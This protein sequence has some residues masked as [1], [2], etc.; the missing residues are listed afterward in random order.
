MIQMLEGFPDGVVAAVA[1]GRVTKRDYDE[2]LIPAV[3]AALGRRQ[4]LRCYYE[5]GQQFS[6]MDVGAVWEDFRL[7][8]ES[9]SRWERIA[10]VTDVEWIRLAIAMFRFLVS[11]EIRIF[12]TGQAAEARRWIVEDQALPAGACC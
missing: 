9:L 4:K 2:V 12:S 1:T 6:G 8:I 10:I 5:L 3:E 7:G 11:G